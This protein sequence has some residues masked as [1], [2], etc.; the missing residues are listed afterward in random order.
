MELSTDESYLSI[1]FQRTEIADAWS[2]RGEEL[3]IEFG[4]R[5]RIHEIEMELKVEEKVKS[6]YVDEVA[7]REELEGLRNA[8][9]EAGQRL[10]AAVEVMQ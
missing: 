10:K 8:L 3:D 4:I 7:L 1:K 6:P 2:M 5:D 9:P